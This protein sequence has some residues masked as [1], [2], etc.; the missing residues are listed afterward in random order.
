[1]QPKV[2]LVVVFIAVFL[3]A[4]LAVFLYLSPADPPH[5][6]PLPKPDAGIKKP[7]IIEIHPSDKN[8]NPGWIG[9]ACKSDSECKYDSGFCLMP[10][11]GYPRGYCSAKC[12]KFCPDRK[13]DLYSV[14]F[15][16]EDPLYGKGGVCLAQCNLHLTPSGCRPGYICTTLQRVSQDAVRL[17]CL[18]DRGSPPPP[19][20]CTRQLDKLGLVYTRPD[21]AD[22]PTKAARPGEAPPD[23]KFCQI[24]TPVLLASPIRSIDYRQK[25]QRHAEHMLVACKMALAIERLSIIL[26]EMD[27]VEVE[28][29]GTYV[30]RGIAGTNSLSGHGH[31]LA[32]DITGFELARDSAIKLSQHWN[33]ADK[34]KKRFLRDL[35]KRIRK[36]K[37]FNVVL[38][39]ASDKAHQDHF[40]LEIR[41]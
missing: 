33:G 37:I 17:V 15:C 13:G 9:S 2:R 1:M 34:K 25:G 27:A 24:D 19:T 14:T 32:I 8:F 5:R 36:E 12:S 7:A 20:D 18:P 40:H 16:I 23:L 11:E 10:E 31:A 41:L 39:P 3:L 4:G 6:K 38:T 28:H 35:V 22:A 30:C 21:L 29:N 26:T